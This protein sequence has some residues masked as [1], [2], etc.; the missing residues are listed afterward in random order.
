MCVGCQKEG[1]NND[2][3]IEGLYRMVRVRGK[4][5]AD[6]NKYESTGDGEGRWKGKGP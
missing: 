4:H 5:V 6:K 2:A 1:E 3:K